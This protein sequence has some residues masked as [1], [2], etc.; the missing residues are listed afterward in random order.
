[1]ITSSYDVLMLLWGAFFVLAFCFFIYGMTRVFHRE[2][3][4]QDSLVAAG[5]QDRA[6]HHPTP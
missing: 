6:G 3:S 2:E 1:M 5:Q 4:R